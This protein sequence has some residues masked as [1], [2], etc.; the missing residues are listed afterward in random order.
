MIPW[1]LYVFLDVSVGR[2]TGSTVDLTH[3]PHEDILAV[4]NGVIGIWDMY[5]PFEKVAVTVTLCWLTRCCIA[6]PFGDTQ[7]DQHRVK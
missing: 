2:L 6:T 1:R 4:W 7:L 3:W 5:L